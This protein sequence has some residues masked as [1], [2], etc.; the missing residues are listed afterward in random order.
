VARQRLGGRAGVTILPPVDAGGTS[1]GNGRPADVVTAIQ[2]LHY[3]DPESRKASIANCHRLLGDG[4]LFV[5]FENIRP[6][7]ARGTEIGKSRWRRFQERSG[8]SPAEAERHLARFDV[9]Y[10]PITAEEYLGV[11]KDVGFR[12]VEILWYSYMQAGFYGIR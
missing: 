8:R 10:F 7:T 11:L 5:T 2:S 3:Q 6:L 9:E 1:I 4:G 12:T